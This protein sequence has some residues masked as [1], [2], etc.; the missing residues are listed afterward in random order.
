MTVIPHLLGRACVLG[1]NLGRFFIKV[2][3]R[4]ICPEAA[5]CLNHVFMFCKEAD[6]STVIPSL[7]E[8]LDA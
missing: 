2:D 1:D 3:R 8:W 5:A 4:W 6:E 7:D